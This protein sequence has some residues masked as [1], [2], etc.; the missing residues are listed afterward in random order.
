MQRLMKWFL[1]LSLLIPFVVSGKQI[2]EL[3]EVVRPSIFLVRYDRVY[4]MEDASVFIYNLKDFKLLKKFGKAGEG[5]REFKY[6]GNDSRPL[7]LI[8][9]NGEMIVNSINKLSYFDKAGNYLR[10]EKIPV[11]RL[12]F[13]VKDKYLGIGPT[14]GPENK[15]RYLGFTVHDRDFKSTEVIFMSDFELGNPEKIRLPMTTFT[16]NPVYKDKIYINSKSDAF[17]I[18]AK[19][20]AGKVLSV[21]EKDY[22]RIE[23]PATF[24]EEV[25]E[26]F[27]TNPRFRQL[28]DFFKQAME[29]RKYYPQIRDIQIV[30]DHIYV[31]S[32]KRKNQLWELRKLGLNGEEKGTVFIP[33]SRYEVLSFYPV[34]YSVYQDRVYSLVEDEEEEVWRIHVTDFN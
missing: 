26:Y 2:A 17:R 22:P 13:P 32:F 8:F 9:N 27:R 21:I 19:D 14:L 25:L 30:D 3:T 4:I 1:F 31:L 11:D 18:V 15:K 33:L 28:S 5:P 23:V 12:L 7:G 10:E 34:F 24:R 6:N 29:I 16:Y 20:V